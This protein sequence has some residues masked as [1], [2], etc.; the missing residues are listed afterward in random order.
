MGWMMI[1]VA[2]IGIWLASKMVGAL[3]KAVFWAVALA[4]LYWVVAPALGLPELLPLLEA[5]MS[6]V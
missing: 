6:P 4:A 1:V 5:A 3:L 2:G